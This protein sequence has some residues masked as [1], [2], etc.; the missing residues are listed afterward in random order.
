MKKN[1]LILNKM[2]S[3]IIINIIGLS[4]I[5]KRRNTKSIFNFGSCTNIKERPE[6]I[7]T[8]NKDILNNFKEII[9]KDLDYLIVEP[10]A[11]DRTHQEYQTPNTCDQQTI[12]KNTLSI[13]HNDIKINLLNK[14]VD[15]KTIKSFF[16]YSI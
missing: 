7:L 14:R 1:K 9:I 3:A 15:L 10:K 16:K 5:H 8:L 12:N 4:I 6:S 13:I 2:N 11:T